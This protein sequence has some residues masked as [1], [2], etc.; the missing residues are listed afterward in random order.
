MVKRAYCHRISELFAKNV[1]PCCMEAFV[2]SVRDNFYED[3]DHMLTQPPHTEHIERGTQRL[4]LII[5]KVC[6]V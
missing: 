6:L 2:F 5:H 1:K 3:T 4:T